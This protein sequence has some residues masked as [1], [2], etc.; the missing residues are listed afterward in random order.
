MACGRR[1][2]STGDKDNEAP[3]SEIEDTDDDEWLERVLTASDCSECDLIQ[4]ACMPDCLECGRGIGEEEHYQTLEGYDVV[5]LVP[6][7]ES[8]Q[9]GRIIRESVRRSDIEVKGLFAVQ[10]LY[11]LQCVLW[12][13]LPDYRLY[14]WQPLKPLDNSESVIAYSSCT[15]SEHVDFTLVVLRPYITLYL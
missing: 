2:T 4:K 1:V 11:C 3:S 5:G 7:L 8:F 13:L 9:T 6:S 12:Q 14:T 15:I 10:R